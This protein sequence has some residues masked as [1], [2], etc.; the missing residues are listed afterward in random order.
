MALTPDRQEVREQ[1]DRISASAPF[2]RGG[3]IKRLLTYVVEAALD[4]LPVEYREAVVRRRIA[5][6]SYAEI[7]EELGRSEG[8]VRNLVCRGLARLS[9]FLEP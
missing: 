7:A 3:R 4:R 9:G 1:L 6:L 8:A 2:A 5:G